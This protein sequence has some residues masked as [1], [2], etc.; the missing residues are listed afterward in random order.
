MLYVLSLFFVVLAADKR[1]LTCWWYIRLNV[2]SLFPVALAGRE[3]FEWDTGLKREFL[4]RGDV[5]GSVLE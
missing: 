3:A 2:L 1:H 5:F 4:F